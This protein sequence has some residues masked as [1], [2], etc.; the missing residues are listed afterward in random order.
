MKAHTLL[1]QMLA[2]LLALAMLAPVPVRG[3]AAASVLERQVK[4]AY[5]YKF[6]GYV[7]WPEG[8]FAKPD[9]P[10]VIGV[11]A[12]EALAAQLEQTVAGRS[13]EGHPV[14]VRRLKR[15]E[16]LSGLHLLFVGGADKTHLGEWLGAARGQPVLTVAEA[17]EG[18]AQGSMINFLMAEERLRFEVALKPVSQ[19]RLRISAR[20][21]AAALR[22][23]GGNAS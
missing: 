10:L 12:S 14:T 18:N 9:A 1:W 2:W 23:A 3:E 22:V 16:S 8:S 6:A 19:S 13:V 20:M 11:A 7:E 4:A 5:L 15:G 17:D 21:L